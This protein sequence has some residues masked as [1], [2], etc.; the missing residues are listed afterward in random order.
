MKRRL[1]RLGLSALIASALIACG[2]G[3]DGINGTN[4]VVTVP[5]NQ[6]NKLVLA[7]NATTPTSE[8]VEVWRT[9]TPKVTVN[10]V[11][12]A[13]PPVVKFTATDAAGNA[14]VGLGNKSKG[15]TATLAALT[16]LRFTL[17]KLV[18]ATATEPS[19]WVSYLVVK[20]TTVAQA[21]GTFAAA[22]SCDEVGKKWCGTY[23]TTES[24]GT[25]VDNGDGTYVYTFARDITQA[26][27]I[28]A[29]LK[30]STDG[31]KKKSDLGDVSYNPSLT[32]RLGIQISGAAPGTGSNVPNAT[33]VIPGVNIA[34]PANVVYDFRPDGGAVTSSR[35]I[36]DK[37]SCDSCHNGKGLAHGQGRNDPNYCVTCHTDQVKYGMSARA[38]SVV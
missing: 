14:L 22:D 34:I 16:N 7:S 9:L 36:V 25:L 38:T 15:S 21:G 19:K 24:E 1:F 28:V 4:T 37:E 35:S 23:P 5:V 8:S 6:A 2:G 13:S 29:S 33:T 32:H 10:G 11:T 26:A 30:D 31:L 27:S 17:A 18:P 12:I 20:P 3:S